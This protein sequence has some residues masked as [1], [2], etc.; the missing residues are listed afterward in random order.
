MLAL[1]IARSRPLL[2]FISK[3]P[4]WSVGRK[5]S[6][7]CPVEFAC[8]PGGLSVAWSKKALCEAVGLSPGLMDHNRGL[9]CTIGQLFNVSGDHSKGPKFLLFSSF[10]QFCCSF[11]SSC[12]APV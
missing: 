4:R 11:H 6:C 1:P 5:V 2:L 8:E 9:F 12:T 3:Q 7:C 10:S